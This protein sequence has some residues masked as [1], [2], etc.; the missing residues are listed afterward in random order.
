MN[1]GGHDYHLGTLTS[2]L[3]TAMGSRPKCRVPK[4]TAPSL[5]IASFDTTTPWVPPKAPT[6]PALR[7]MIAWRD[8][9]DESAARELVSQLGPLVRNIAYQRLPLA[10][11][12]EDAVQNTLANLFRSLE[13]FDPRVPLGAWAVCLTKNVCAN[14]LRSYRRRT[15]FSSADLGIDQVQDLET[16]EGLPSLEDT[17]IAREDLRH[18]INC[19][20][21]MG[22]TDKL[23]IDILLVG[24]GSGEDVSHRAGITAGAAR[25]RACR[26]RSFLRESLDAENVRR[27]RPAAKP[28]RRQTTRSRRHTTALALV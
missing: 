12:V 3:S 17:I 6:D 21:A 25:V 2:I 16:S 19:A 14:L 24:G 8:H 7:A 9:G 1:G 15:V 18:I 26:L 10:W 22:T 13:R 23:V 5:M 4:C 11:M 27:E 28:E 20:T